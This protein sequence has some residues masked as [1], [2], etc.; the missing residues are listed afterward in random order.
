[1]ATSSQSEPGTE[2]QGRFAA[3]GRWLVRHSRTLSVP[4]VISIYG[5]LIY[6]L[7]QDWDTL[8]PI[9]RQ[10]RYGYLA[11]SSLLLFLALGIVAGRWFFTLRLLEAEIGWWESLRIWF[12]S[13]AGRYIPGSIW[14][15]V[16]RFYWSAG[17]VP[18]DKMAIS[19]GIELV[20]RVSSESVLAAVLLFVWALISDPVDNGLAWAAAF[21]AA[22]LV[23]HMVLAFAGPHLLRRLAALLGRKAPDLAS[24]EYVSR[25]HSGLVALWGYFAA[26]VIAVGI[27]F[28]FYVDA[29][30]PVDP[31][32]LPALIGALSAATVISF[33]VPLAP[34]GWGVREGILAFLLARFMPTSVAVM[35]SVTS[36]VWLAI[37]EALWVVVV[38]APTR[39]P[40]TVQNG[41]E[42][43]ADGSLIQDQE[44]R[45][46]RCK[47]KR[48]SLLP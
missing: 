11:F 30:Y 14:P 43:G 37:V 28:Y 7:V 38:V 4:F 21:A 42:S 17:V 39:R 32:A 35:I 45:S 27:A 33:L 6:R 48:V 3:A 23:G 19:L 1:V 34:N 25:G 13:Q 29:F 12:L 16:G 18:A 46:S 22:V 44:Q 31:S 5:Y 26:S 9:F 40:R 41:V 2:S 8:G 36:R 47:S 20:L 15:F 24:L 10:A